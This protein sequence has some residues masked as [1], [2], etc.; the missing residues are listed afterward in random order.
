MSLMLQLS[1]WILRSFVGVATRASHVGV[2]ALVVGGT[3]V[4]VAVLMGGTF[5]VV[6]LVGDTFRVILLGPSL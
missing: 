2:G 4:G 6:K 5:E 3:L 1:F